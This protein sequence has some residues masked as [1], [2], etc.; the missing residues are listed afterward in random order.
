MVSTDSQAV[1]T[2]SF[3][4]IAHS[5]LVM[6]DSWPVRRHFCL[7]T[8]RF[9]VVT[10]ASVRGHVI[11]GHAQEVPARSENSQ[12]QPGTVYSS[13]RALLSHRPMVL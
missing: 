5:S 13:I 12:N 3:L 2:H 7:V 9:P 8:R 11:S 1:I 6:T 4:V 10:W